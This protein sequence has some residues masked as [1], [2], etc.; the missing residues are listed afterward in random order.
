MVVLGIETSCDETAAAVVSGGKILS[1]VVTSSVPLHEKFG[2]VIP[3][4]ASRFH[5]EYINQVVKKA[6]KKARKTFKDIELIAVTDS[7]GLP[8]SLITGVSFAKA[9]SYSLGIPLLL[10]D[11]LRAHLQANFLTE[12]GAKVKF[13]FIGVVVSGGHTNI[14][15]CRSFGDFKLIGRTRDDA[16]G[17]AFDKVARVLGIGYPGGP[18]IEK[19]ARKFKKGSSIK[20]APITAVFLSLS[21]TIQGKMTTG[22]LVPSF[23][24]NSFSMGSPLRVLRKDS[25]VTCSEL[26]CFTDKYSP[27]LIFF[28]SSRE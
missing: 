4:I 24:M 1:N 19:Y 16:I 15:V 10:L 21:G 8:G 5:I 13:P 25:N 2:G 17:E 18:K 14:F 6:L 7:P 12:E 27:K 26:L 22:N 23:L 20:I 11:H 9:L 28:N 3:E